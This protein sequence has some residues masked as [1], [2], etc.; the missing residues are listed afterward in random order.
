MDKEGIVFGILLALL[1]QG[2]YE[3]IFY[4]IQGKFVEEWAASAA[5]VVTFAVL[6]G[7]FYWKG[8]FKKTEG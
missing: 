2:F 1:V 8:Y 6:F 3:V 5:S 7:L 4:A